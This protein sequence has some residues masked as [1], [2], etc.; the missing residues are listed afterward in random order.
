MKYFIVDYL[1]RD[2]EHEYTEHGVLSARSSESAYTKAE[3]GRKFFTRYGWEE[4][5]ERSG[6]YEIPKAD[7]EVLGKYFLNI[8]R[9]LAKKDIYLG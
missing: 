8:D 1:T 2:G 6:V 3:R 4:F 9:L 7:F 5:C